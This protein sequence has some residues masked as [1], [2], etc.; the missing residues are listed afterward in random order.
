MSA[1][2]SDLFLGKSGT[3]TLF[4]IDNCTRAVDIQKFS[5]FPT[6]AEVLLIPGAHLEVVDVGDMGNGLVIITL[7]QIPPPFDAIDFDWDDGNDSAVIEP[8]P[9]PPAGAQPPA[10]PPAPAVQSPAPAV[11]AEEE[12]AESDIG[13]DF[14]DAEEESVE[15]QL[16]A[17][18]FSGEEASLG[19]QHGQTVQQASNWLLE[20][21]EAQAK[22][23][24]EEKAKKEAKEKA[25]KVAKEK[26]KKE[27]EE[28]A[29]KEA[30]EKAKKEAEEKAKQEKEE[31]AKQGAEE[32]VKQ[33]EEEKAKKEAAE[34][35]K[36]KAEEKV[37]KEKEEQAKKEAAEMA[38]K[39]AEE[40]AK[41]EEDGYT[42][43]SLQVEVQGVFYG[44]SW[45][46][47]DGE[48]NPV[49]REFSSTDSKG[50]QQ[51]VASCWVVDVPN[52]FGKMQHRF[53]VVSNTEGTL[54]A[55]AAAGGAEKQRWLAAME[56]GTVAAH[57][58]G[59]S[60]SS[61]CRYSN[62]ACCRR[63]RRQQ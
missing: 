7:R 10:A 32:K 61:R 17:M 34:M 9:S 15:Q 59:V 31:K 43:G 57:T 8:I 40:K 29:K 23:G 37:K 22:K 62:Y 36:K 47:A 2:E 24:A 18:G 44:S 33:Q 58:T 53:N 16:V 30:E 60:S 45:H 12:E 50:K 56:A 5:A 55:L 4:R 49:T 35:A 28:K 3:R 54:V 26:A 46:D 11:Q 14:E 42:L 41:K 13:E 38:K 63:E 19:A 1:L 25:K 20:Q 27:A 39:K 48:F 6:E 52:S 21:K 51:R